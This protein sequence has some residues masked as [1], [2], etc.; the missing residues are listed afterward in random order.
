MTIITVFLSHF[1]GDR[2]VTLTTGK[3]FISAM[4]TA[5]FLFS[6]MGVCAIGLSLGRTPRWAPRRHDP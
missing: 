3:E 4:Q 1:L 6:I 2:P 5:M